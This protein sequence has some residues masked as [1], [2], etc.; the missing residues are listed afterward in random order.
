MLRN[1]S[2]DYKID[3][4][5]L[6]LDVSGVNK[7]KHNDA[8]ALAMMAISRSRPPNMPRKNLAH[9]RI[10]AR[11]K[12]KSAY[13]A[14]YG[15]VKK[16]VHIL[17]STDES[18]M[19]FHDHN[20]FTGKKIDI[21]LALKWA[22]DC[23]VY[24]ENMGTPYF[25]TRNFRTCR[26]TNKKIEAW[27]R[28]KQ[29]DLKQ[30]LNTRVYMDNPNSEKGFVNLGWGSKVELGF[31]EYAAP[32]RLFPVASHED[33]IPYLACNIP[34]E[35]IAISVKDKALMNLFTGFPIESV[36]LNEETPKYLGSAIHSH[37]LKVIC[38]GDQKEYEHLE[39]TIAD[40][41]QQPYRISNVAHI[42]YGG[43]GS[44]KSALLQF[45]RQLIGCAHV[46]EFN[47]INTYMRNFN[48]DHTCAIL[49]IFEE[50]GD[51]GEQFVNNGKLKA[52][53]TKTMIRIEIKNAAIIH[54]RNCARLW[55][56]SNHR[57]NLHIDHDDRRFTHHEVI[58][59][60]ADDHSYFDPIWASLKDEQFIRACFEYFAELKYSDEFV[61]HAFV[62]KY[63]QEQ[64][65]DSLSLPLKFLNDFMYA[66]MIGY[67]IIKDEINVSSRS[68]YDAYVEW[69]RRNNQIKVGR[70]GTLTKIFEEVGIPKPSRKYI[71]GTQVTCY[72]MDKPA[73]LAGFRKYLK[74]PEFEFLIEGSI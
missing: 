27:G 25:M 41:I 71:S 42:F 55:F 47:D 3:L 69:A 33:F 2:D 59:D 40:M 45:M 63:K 58:N 56:I 73:I 44:G 29:A 46:M 43:Q 35:R 28:S 31:M 62:T 52:E 14:W 54:M 64:K 48:D 19:I 30:C 32:L 49:K 7:E 70:N 50:V 17:P 38:H 60:N 8:E 18:R 37:L 61:T 26:Y 9:L 72:V 53:I 23:L 1:I 34:D 24:V 74:N 65:I 36:R 12:D 4:D 11:E 5:A 20:E 68:V 51:K 57:N 16:T 13:F 66:D 21:G 22:R 6:A 10:Q 39:G 15:G 67:P